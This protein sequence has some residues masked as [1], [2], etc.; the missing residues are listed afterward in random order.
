[1]HYGWE[2]VIGGGGHVDV[3]VGVDRTFAAH[4]AAED[5]DGP[6]GDDFVGV[7]V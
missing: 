2:G 4:G 6:I 5:L 3:I 1:M 7:H